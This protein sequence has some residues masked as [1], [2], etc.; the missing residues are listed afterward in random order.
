MACSMFSGAR[1]IRRALIS[2]PDWRERLLLD[3]YGRDLEATVLDRVTARLQA[4]RLADERQ[5]ADS[6]RCRISSNQ[7]SVTTSS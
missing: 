1:Q 2:G 6:A 3:L 4:R 7:P 5:R